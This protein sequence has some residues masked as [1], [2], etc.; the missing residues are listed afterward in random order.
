MNSNIKTALKLTALALLFF[1][2]AIIRQLWVL[3]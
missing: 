1:C 3:S 2:L